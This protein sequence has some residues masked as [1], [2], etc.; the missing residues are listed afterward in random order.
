MRTFDWNRL[1]QEPYR[2]LFPLGAAFGCLGV[3]HWLLYAMGMAGASPQY[4]ASIQL[5]SYLYCFIAGFLWTALPRMSGTEKA[6]SFELLML[7]G[8]LAAQ[9]VLLTLGKN[10]IAQICFAGLLI[11][12]ISFA[13]RR[14]AARRTPAQGP[15]EFIWI[16][17][18]IGFGLIG[19]GLWVV[20]ALV[21]M[22]TWLVAD[23]RV[24][25]Q[26]G[27]TLSLVVGVAGFMAP[28]LTGHAK[29][30]VQTGLAADSVEKARRKRIAE[31]L[32]AAGLLG[33]SFIIEGIG[34]IRTAY[35]LR[36]IIVTAELGWRARWWEPP[37]VKDSY[38]W[39]LWLSLW[40]VIVGLWAVACW[41]THRVAMLHLVLIGGFSLMIFTVG[42]MV[43]L[44]HAGKAE[45]LHSPL[46]I[47]KV[48]AVGVIGA[49]TARV[50]ADLWT[51]H[52]FVL[53]AA[54]ALSWLAAGIS[55]FVFIFPWVLR[56]AP[57]SEFERIHE[58]AK[59]RV[60]SERSIRKPVC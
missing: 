26:Q 39:L 43:V 47:L 17:I 34:A 45:M 58:Q 25:A 36:A 49:T 22:P 51:E 52:Y 28:R 56:T 9:T 46:W 7:L 59:R 14:M 12:L 4:H 40:F 18:G 1:R 33:L 16:P 38:V 41:P 31:H 13:A 21:A 8:L 6:S 42:T 3:T 2:L 50:L 53:L 10:T 19:S 35:A 20:G 11:L 24:M 15:T 60:L 32:L 48:V 5:G 29:P 55:W 54:A 44:S 57:E 37:V 27:F 23:G 30:L